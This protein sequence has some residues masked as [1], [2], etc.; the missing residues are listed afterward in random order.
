MAKPIEKIVIVGG[1]TAGWMAASALSQYLKDKPVSVQLVESD[2][3]GTV[4]VGE[5]TVPGIK[6]FNR[7]LGIGERDF[8]NATQATFKLGIEFKDWYTKGSSFFH[9]FADYGMPINGQS[10][11]QHWLQLHKNGYEGALESFCLSTQMALENRFSLPDAE[12]ASPLTRYNYAYHFDAFLY[13][14]FLREYAEARGV[15]RIEGMISSVTLDE[16]SG[17]VKDVVLASGQVVAGELFIDCSGFKA[18]LIEGA[19]RTGYEDWSHWLPC[20][21]A[22]AMQT[23]NAEAPVPYTCSTAREAGWQWKIPLQHRAGN[24]YVYCDKYI[25]DQE[26]IDTLRKHASGRA[27]TEPRVIKFTTGVRKQFWNKNC[28]ALG[29]ASGFL[30]PLESTSISLIQTGIDKLLNHFPDA[31]FSPELRDEANRLNLLEYARLRDFLILHY[32]ANKRGDTQF[33]LDVQSMDIPEMLA[34]KIKRFRAD[35]TLIT[36]D[37]ETFQD[38][39]WLSMYNGFKIIPNQTSI[40]LSGTERDSL[41]RMLEK[42]KSAI[43]GGVGYAPLHH[44]FLKSMA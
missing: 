23:E 22:V 1:G 29:L 32:K 40:S 6:Y 33:W 4:G 34:E 42:M 41:A 11:Y 39:S 8:I 43:A 21:S 9:P 24:G 26:A 14:K 27:L 38:A 37:Q 3:I 19:L 13:A 15:Q 18:L 31:D 7:Q 12:P 20:N 17:F 25:S 10:F 5:A 36:Y 44:E 35:G 28:V 16:H 2:V 30:E